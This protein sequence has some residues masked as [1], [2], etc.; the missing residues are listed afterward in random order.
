MDVRFGW[1]SMIYELS[2]DGQ[3]EQGDILQNLPFIDPFVSNFM[4]EWLKLVNGGEELADPII[5]EIEP[6]A[7]IGILLNQSC[8]IR[9][10]NNLVFA[11]ISAIKNPFSPNSGK[12]VKQIRKI[13]RDET[14][15]YYLPISKDIFEI[16]HIVDFRRIFTVPAELILQ[17]LD[18]FFVARLKKPATII[19]KEKICRFFTRLAFDDVIFFA[20]HELEAYIKETNEP[21]SSI[22]AAL[23][24]VGRHL[25]LD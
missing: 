9:R 21:T 2:H 4:S 18:S 1:G 25:N 15:T 6:I 12:K 8:D 13:I 19:L 17:D 11:E 24:Q 23:K 7:K 3:L 14:R 22:E 10:E 20:D 5:S 16:P